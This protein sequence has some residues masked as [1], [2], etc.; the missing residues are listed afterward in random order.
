MKRTF[1]IEQTTINILSR[2]QALI[3]IQR[4]F[5]SRIKPSRHLQGRSAHVRGHGL[6]CGELQDG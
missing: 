6:P 3:G 4:K 2:S 5:P 1:V